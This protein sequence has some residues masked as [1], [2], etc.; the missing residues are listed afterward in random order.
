MTTPASASIATS[1][2]AAMVVIAPA[3]IAQVVT[4]GDVSPTFPV[5]PIAIVDLTGQRVF[6]GSTVAGVGRQGTLSV[7]A[8]SS[9]TAAQIVPG[10]G[11]LGVGQVTVSGANSV[12]NLTG[13]AAANGLDIGSWGTGTVTV[14]NGGRIACSTPTVCGFSSIGN[15]AGS[16]GTLAINGGTVSGLG[17]IAVGFG[18]I[19][20]GFGT[21][22]ANTSA[23]LSITNGGILSSAGFTSV[24]RNIGQTGVVSGNVIINGA[25]SSWSITREPNVVGQAFLGIAPD[26][27]GNAN[28][29]ISNGGNLTITGSRADPTTDSSI[30]GFNMSAAAG[31]TCTL[32]VTTGGSVRIGGDTGVITLGGSSFVSSPG[33]NSTLNITAGGTVSGTGANGLSFVAIGQSLGTGTVNVSGVG[34]Q[35]VVAGVGGQNTQGLDGVGGLVMVGRNRNAIGG[36]SGTLNVTEGGSVFISDNGQIASPNTMGLRLASGA[37]S[38]GTV[39][40][41][42]S[43]SSIVISST[44]G[45]EASPH[46][47]VGNGGIG[48]MTISSGGSVSVQ[49]TGQRN[50]TVGNTNTGS[51]TLVMTTGGQI[52]ASRF[53]VGDNGGSGTATINNSTV[54][55]D[56]AIF[57]NGINGT[58]FGAGVRIGRGD[59]AIGVLNLQNGATININNTFDSAGVLLGGTSVLAGGSGTLN[60][61]GGSSINFTG[62]ATGAS[63]HV[64]ATAGSAGFM[65]MAGNSVVNLGAV[66]T[67]V[68]ATAAGSVGTLTI[69]GGSSINAN[70][71]GIGGNSDTA[72]GGIG[73]AIVT[74]LGSALRANGDS[75]FIS[76]GRGGTERY[77]SRIRAPSRASS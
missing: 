76:V 52:N 56:G 1:L 16:T 21:A 73:G 31:A 74:G 41:S 3:A 71:I 72:A 8:D 67:A 42:G 68:V 15:A 24:A 26:T 13:G 65:T 7:T 47:L 53:A 75:G 38:F 22:G 40:V 62:T 2:L 34:S 11:G 66:G 36:G 12:I 33:A 43:G 30:P 46:V 35:L 58:P 50:F 19:G 9:L 10:I 4:T 51:G 5:P 61:S 48:Q 64:G 45:S 60:M 27:N 39:T 44:G 6:I 20:T 69:G 17:Q 54:N 18:N 59:G 32:T 23:T 28:V 29:T 14:S 57:N 25:G 63:L 70:V 49:G 37:D 77:L 55:L